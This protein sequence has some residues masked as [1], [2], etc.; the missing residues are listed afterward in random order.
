[1]S[2]RATTPD[3]S[4]RPECGARKTAIPRAHQCL[5][6][7]DPLSQ[8][9]INNNLQG[10]FSLIVLQSTN[11]NFNRWSHT[12]MYSMYSYLTLLRASTD[13]LWNLRTLWETFFFII[14][15]NVSEY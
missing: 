8:Y 10:S 12:A 7:H 13:L 11:K 5:N 9:K 4:N 2:T 6:A 15:N 3:L 1:M 14:Y